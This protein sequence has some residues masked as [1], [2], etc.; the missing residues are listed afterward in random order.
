MDDSYESKVLELSN[1]EKFQEIFSIPNNQLNLFIKLFKSMLL[2]RRAEEKLAE[3]KEA[4]NIK[5]PVHLGAGQEA[6]AVGISENLKST[7]RIFGA[8]RSHSHLLAMEECLF[9]LFSEVLGKVSGLSKGMGGSMHLT[10]PEKG[11]IG[12]V[13]IVAGTVPLALGAAFNAKYQGTDDIGVAY[14]GDGAVE[15]GIVHESLNLASTLGIPI[16]FVVENNLFS[17]HMHISLRQPKNS[18]ARFAVANNIGCRVI[19]GNNI[20]EVYETSRD[21]ISEI[22]SKKTPMLLEAVTYRHYGHVDW[23]KDIDVG[24]NRSAKDLA[25][26]MKRD[27]IERLRSALKSCH[28]FNE[29]DLILIDED[30]KNHIS[31]AWEKAEDQNYAPKS[32]LNK[33]VLFDG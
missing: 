17:S 25:N 29:D 12:S 31:L 23:R 10:Y 32:N 27:P 8:H 19:D 21:L 33:W 26:W 9:E 18:T 30:I 1:P 20:K 16:L 14:L 4:G 13:P 5:G 11:F 3:Q 22:R 15:E 6:V 7:D 28:K 2:I 24:V